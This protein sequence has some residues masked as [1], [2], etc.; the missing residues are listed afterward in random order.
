M[1]TH[2]LHITQH[3]PEETVYP[4][5]RHTSLHITQPTHNT[6]LWS[7]HVYTLYYTS[8]TLNTLKPPHWKHTLNT[9]DTEHAEYP[10][11]YT[12]S[13]HSSCTATCKIYTYHMH[14]L[15]YKPTM[16]FYFTGDFHG[17][18]HGKCWERCVPCVQCPQL[19]TRFLCCVEVLRGLGLWRRNVA[20]LGLP[21]WPY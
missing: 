10:C 16:F 3:I 18:L 13:T 9:S 11:V 8:H 15:H 4:T 2:L 19:Q 7:H 5:W 14:T 6:T 1:H 21:S 17:S 20:P 12:H